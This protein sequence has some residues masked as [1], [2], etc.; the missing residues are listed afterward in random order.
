MS[1]EDLSLDPAHPRQTQ[2]LYGHADA[3]RELSSGFASGRLP[4]AWLIGG[5]RGIGK[6]TLAYR[7]ARFILA[8]SGDNAVQSSLFGAAPSSV[9]LE[10]AG[11][12]PAFRR[13][14][15]RAHADLLT[16]ERSINI[17]TGKLRQEIA[18]EDARR[19]P[20]FFAKTAGEGGYRIAIVDAADELNRH[21]ANALLKIVEEPPPQALILIVTH[22]SGAVLPT[23]RSRCRRLTL[24]PLSDKAM[25]AFFK[26]RLP[27]LAGDDRAIILRLAE[28]SP[29]RAL[30]L[31]ELDAPELFKALLKL[32]ETVPRLDIPSLHKFADELGRGASD[33]SF[34]TAMDLLVWWLSRLIKGVGQGGWSEEVL[35]GE[36]AILHQLSA[37]VKL[38]RWI[39]AWEKCCRLLE[40]RDAVNLDRK[41]VIL[42]VFFTISEAARAA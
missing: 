38:D 35:P 23:I 3:E 26:E 37:S 42:S 17:K 19:M 41:Q 32:L 29:G 24:R 10:L 6:A 11:E 40:R 20:D 28:G 15:S 22:S 8:N 9:S 4:H 33:A 2:S 5:P 1:D 27:N 39:D 18:V 12:H 21:S 30:N 31:A 36:A 13:V 16:I 7:F 25:D 34:R 14:A